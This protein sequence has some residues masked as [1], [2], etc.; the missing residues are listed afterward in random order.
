MATGTVNLHRVLRAPPERIYRAFLEPH[1]I[2]R[3]LPP[4][5]LIC[6]VHHMD[7]REG[8]THKMSFHNFRTGQSQSFGG[9]YL[10]LKPFE[11]IRYSDRFDDANLPGEMRVTV[12][13]RQVSCGTE[14]TIVQEGIPEVIPAELCYLGWQE[15]LLQLAHLV[16]PEISG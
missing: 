11:K 10:E 4:Y 15:S 6:Q 3:W 12:S 8:G 2:A 5:G 1:A 7:A 9:E 16:E 13:L 14:V